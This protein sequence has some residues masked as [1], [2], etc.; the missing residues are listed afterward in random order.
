M[1]IDEYTL[2]SGAIGGD[3]DIGQY[4]LDE[5]DGILKRAGKSFLGAAEGVFD[6]VT[7][8]VPL[9]GVAAATGLYNTV[10]LIANYVA[11][12]GTMQAISTLDIVDKFDQAFETGGSLADFY[13]EHATGIELGGAILGSFVPGGL[14]VKG[15]RLAFGSISKVAEA[16]AIAN[17]GTYVGK[18]ASMYTGLAPTAAKTR[19]LK[20]SY[21]SILR[22]GG[23]DL[24]RLAPLDRMKYA[25]AT[26][27]QAGLEAMI[28]EVGSVLAQSQNPTYKDIND[29]GDF[30]EHV[31]TA[32]LFGGALGGIAG[33][34][35]W[36]SAKF[37]PE[38]GAKET[39]L[40]D[41][42]QV[43]G[44]ARQR[45]I[46][47]ADFGSKIQNIA[48][49]TKLVQLASDRELKESALSQLIDN[50]YTGLPASKKD[51]ALASAKGWLADRGQSIDNLIKGEVIKLV[52][53][54]RG[55]I[56]PGD[57]GDDLYNALLK[58]NTQGDSVLPHDRIAQILGG[59]RSVEGVK[60]RMG[61]DGMPEIIPAYRLS[62][63]EKEK[64]I[65]ALLG[66]KL[67]KQ[68]TERN[69]L[70]KSLRDKFEAN[71]IGRYPGK[72]AAEQFQE[73]FNLLKAAEAKGR[74]ED[75]LLIKSILKDFDSL[76]P[77][78]A[79]KIGL[80]DSQYQEIRKLID[81]DLRPGT[82]NF[83]DMVAMSHVDKPIIQLGDLM[84]KSGSK[85]GFKVKNGMLYFAGSDDVLIHNIRG[86]VLSENIPS[87]SIDAQARWAFAEDFLA[88]KNPGNNLTFANGQFNPFLLAAAKEKGIPVSFNGSS[89]SQEIADKFLQ[90]SKLNMYN[91][92]RQNMKM[93]EVEARLYADL[94]L[95]GNLKDWKLLRGREND[96]FQR[97][98]VILEYDSVLPLGEFEKKTL[99]GVRNQILTRQ[100][101]AAAQAYTI[102]QSL[103]IEIPQILRETMGYLMQHGNNGE[104]PIDFAH[105]ANAGLLTN[106]NG[107]MFRINT[108]ATGVGTWLRNA[109]S[110]RNEKVDAVLAGPIQNILKGAKKTED[111]DL[112]RLIH[113]QVTGGGTK[114]YDAELALSGTLEPEEVYNLLKD[115]GILKKGQEGKVWLSREA[116]MSINKALKSKDSEGAL[117]STLENLAANPEKHFLIPDNKNVE[118]LLETYSNFEGLNRMGHL[119]LL[120]SRGYKVDDPIPG[121]LYF[122]P[123]D[124]NR[125]PYFVMVKDS[126]MSGID[127]SP[128]YSFLHAPTP[129]AL[130]KRVEKLQQNSDGLEIIPKE[131][132]EKDLKLRGEFDW[133]KSFYS[134][135]IDSKLHSKG[136]FSE[137]TLRNGEELLQEMTTHLKEGNSSLMRGLVKNTT[138]DFL[139][140]NQLMSDTLVAYGKSVHGKALQR[141]TKLV[142]NDDIYTQINRALLD[143]GPDENSAGVL[144][145]V[146]RAQN[147]IVDFADNAF[148]WIRDE[149]SAARNLTKANKGQFDARVDFINN[150]AKR[151]GI[152]LTE[153]NAALLADAERKYGKSHITH[154]FVSKLNA[155]S[156]TVTLGL[157]GAFAIVQSL[158]LPITIN[159]S[160][161][162]LLA[163]APPEIQEKIREIGIAGVA[164]S[165]GRKA[166]VDYWRNIVQ[167]NRLEALRAGKVLSPE[168][169]AAVDA[170]LKTDAG[171][172]YQEM[173]DLGLIPPSMRQTMI[174]VNAISDMSALDSSKLNEK[175]QSIVRFGTTPSRMAETFQR[176]AALRVADAIAEAAKLDPVKKYNLL[177]SFVTQSSGVFTASQRPGM[178][179]G[180]IG[181]AFGL[182]KSYAINMMQAFGRHIEDR[183]YVGL[184]QL[185]ALQGTIFGAKTLPGMPQIN[186]YILAQNQEDWRDLYTTTDMLLGRGRGQDLMYGYASAISHIG[187]TSRGDFNM[188]PFGS[189]FDIESYPAINQFFEVGRAIGAT[190]SQL[191]NGASAGT[192]LLD[193]LAHQSLSRPLARVAE[194]ATGRQSTR[195]GATVMELQTGAEDAWKWRLLTRMAGAK[196]NDEAI[197][198]DALYRKEAY[199]AKQTAEGD[200]IRLTLRNKIAAGEDIDFD[201]VANSMTEKG[202]LPADF[203]RWITGI[204]RSV[205]QSKV[206]KFKTQ[207][208][209]NGRIEHFQQLDQPEN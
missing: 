201:E 8:G 131:K 4:Q 67:G 205:E 147:E 83:F 190:M 148:T 94:P 63:E 61:S 68:E 123:L 208:L 153:M 46:Q 104:N 174:E 6:F 111:L 24:L 112:L 108:I 176:Y 76:T 53:S 151:L 62:Q 44:K 120:I 195:T 49:G 129:D 170:F 69:K 13:S 117:I 34:F 99:A 2:A 178:F 128:K 144:G 159:S 103:G 173:S 183:D 106:A 138:G 203:R 54:A 65:K 12:E 21:D 166:S 204:Y 184:L 98:N 135:N 18:M 22:T 17:S 132:I 10:P 93:S 97:R 15:S 80:P 26:A 109:I 38:A 134:Y 107:S 28:F 81:I 100:I 82:R 158:S 25:V 191:G 14:A 58:L 110:T 89:I 114:Y 121:Q 90:Q 102:A 175:L 145:L 87:S 70:I 161:R 92:A 136:V 36:K 39:T 207:L 3:Y 29:L 165:I 45:I 64:I 209:K 143:I 88:Q 75:S 172:F 84:T 150:E 42:G 79:R 206:D 130:A 180:S 27:G 187:L 179:Q 192:A 155:I 122:P 199:R 124:I 125:S 163:D 162:R 73:D 167:I 154:A 193:G 5:E 51:A 47:I 118:A 115:F 77:E 66:T 127:G 72:K 126:T 1:A 197:L 152:D 182:Y 91:H 32:G 7:K 181:G 137:T 37:A 19:I 41:F 52:N 185:S 156:A 30:V 141:G 9:A 200:A 56:E 188:N 74:E 189:P 43:V 196:P 11:G 171:R 194:Y 146:I 202:I 119:R 105:A 177:H 23:D 113:K 133:A 57:I 198:S 169:Q 164:G 116:A 95:E 78:K 48:P 101:D 140:N 86:K 35:F 50:L 85:E 60:V 20:A 16:A 71:K 139:D 40:L 157:D 31:S 168:K 55:K 186:N 142:G 160:L 59:A 149:V 96:F 33:N